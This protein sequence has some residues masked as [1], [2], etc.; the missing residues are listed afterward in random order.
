MNNGKKRPEANVRE[1]LESLRAKLFLRFGEKGAR[2]IIIGVPLLTIAFVALVAL[3]LLLPVKQIEVAGEVTMFNESEIISA[4]SIEEGDSLF[5][6]S[7][8]SIKRSVK[9]NLPLAERVKVR[10]SIFGKLRIEV[11]FAD[12]EFYCKVNDLYYAID[13]NLR[14]LDSDESRSKY[15]AYGAVFVCLPDV[16]EPILGEKLVVDVHQ[17][18]L[19][20]RR[21][22]LLARNVARLLSKTKLSYTHTNSARGNKNNLLATVLYVADS[23]A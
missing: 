19:T 2:R 6:K 18:A 4:A 3:L 16:R 15:S 10:K 8:A 17:L 1:A 21:A 7:S 9:K 23:L 22:S 13:E 12:V 11:E 14:V 20:N 5:L